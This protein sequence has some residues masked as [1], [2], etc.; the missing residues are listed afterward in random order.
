MRLP[1]VVLGV[2]LVLAACT[3]SPTSS[4]C[5]V[6]TVAI[7]GAPATL[8]VG[9]SASLTA[10][11]TQEGCTGLTVSWNSSHPALVSVSGAGV[12]TGLAAGGP[13]TIT[14]SAGGQSGT[15]Q[16]TVTA[17]VAARVELSEA[18]LVLAPG[19]TWQLTAAAFDA[20]DAMLP[21]WPFTW[22]STQAA[23]ASV[24]GGLVSGLARGTTMVRASA[25]DP[26]AEAEVTVAAPRLGFFWL[27]ASSPGGTGVAP[28]EF[29]RY[30]TVAG[31]NFHV[32][33]LSP[34][35]YQ[36]EYAGLSR[37]GGETENLFVTPYG[38]SAGVYCNI[39]SW[40][41]EDTEMG[42]RG[43]AGT[44]VATSFTFLVVGS[45]TF[46]GRSAYAW[47]SGGSSAAP[48]VATPS[49]RY[50]SAQRPISVARSGIGVYQ[51]TFLGLGRQSAAD[52][53]GMMVSAYGGNH[54]CQLDGWNSAGE[55]LVAT[56]R[57]FSAAGAPVD[58]LF[59]VGVVSE[60]RA[61]AKL[62][63]AVADQPT[64]TV[65]YTPTNSRVTGGGSVSIH[66]TGVGSYDVSFNG[67]TRADGVRESFQVAPM[68]STAARC[69]ISNWGLSGAGILVRVLCGTP[70]GTLADT[71]FVIVGVQ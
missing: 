22:S 39:S 32:R 50:S 33:S 54:S 71:R 47:A 59:T 52:R 66:R 58:G 41:N 60:A 38:S 46:G 29:Y 68:G 51:V 4:T 3:D 45:A 24:A 2:G 56:V 19:Q 8:S 27:H 62:G 30:S 67:L 42:C 44:P 1:F 7:T 16:I 65:D 37:Q 11:V 25:G 53:E 61:G 57:C 9:S 28:D 21:D 40:S 10:Q 15:V 17:P 69:T 26:F 36:V 18:R 48:Y 35:V 5:Q 14:A 31:T 13:V 49:Y 12:V 63:F 6:Q 70:A 55:D 34:G 64:T 23:T 43:P 20:A